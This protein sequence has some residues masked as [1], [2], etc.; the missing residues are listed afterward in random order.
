MISVTATTS[1]IK[2]EVYRHRAA[3]DGEF[4]AILTFY[5]QVLEED[6]ELCEGV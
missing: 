1:K 4:N 3:T 6:R 5:R 2:N